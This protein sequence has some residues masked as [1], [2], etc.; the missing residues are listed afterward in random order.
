VHSK[1]ECDQHNLAHVARNKKNKKKLKQTNANS[2]LVRNELRSAK[3]VQKEPGLWRKLGFV[4]MTLISFKS[5]MKS[6]GSER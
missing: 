6:R 1:A 4:K 2:H 3:A 5:G